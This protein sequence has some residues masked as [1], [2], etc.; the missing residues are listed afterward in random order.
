MSIYFIGALFVLGMVD[1]DE[2]WYRVLFAM[3]LW[4]MYLGFVVK[5]MFGETENE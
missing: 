2:K 1:G 5:E 3:L 4:P